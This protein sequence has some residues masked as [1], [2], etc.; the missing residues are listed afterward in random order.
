MRDENQAFKDEVTINSKENMLTDRYLAKTDPSGY[1]FEKPG[2]TI[3]YTGKELNTPRMMTVKQI[4]DLFYSMINNSS[5]QAR[6]AESESNINKLFDK[7]AL[8]T[9]ED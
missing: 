5:A 1:L 2:M 6:I 3:D 7:T 8:L 9:Y 4:R